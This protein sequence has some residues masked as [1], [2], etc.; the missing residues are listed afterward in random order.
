[1]LKLITG[2]DTGGAE[3]MLYKTVTHLDKDKYKPIV[4]SLLPEGRISGMLREQNSEVHSLGMRNKF[5]NPAVLFRLVAL[6]RREK[7]EILHS[8]MFHADLLGRIAGKLAGVPV[9]IS[10]I[11]N[12]NIGGKWRERML[13]VSDFMVDRVT[14]VCRAA[15]MKQVAAGTTRANKLH[16]IYN[17]IELGKYPP[18][19]DAQ[20]AEVRREWNIPDDCRVLMNVGRL[21]RQK[22]QAGL[23]NSFASLLGEEP[24]CRLVIVGDG[25]LRGALEEQAGRLGIA[26]RVIFTGICKDIPRML[27]AA[28]IFVLSSLWEGFPNVVI[29][30]M[31][32]RKPVVATNAGGTPEVIED[33]RSGLLVEPGNAAALTA[34][35]TRLLR[36][37][38][39]QLQAMGEYGRSVVERDFTI[40]RTIDQTE[41]M[42]EGLMREKGVPV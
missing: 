36:L 21:E 31:A 16:V 23:L 35:L 38:R 13:G 34:A 18:G 11:R 42:Y 12:E 37:P 5:P 27:Q 25:S 8:Y 29:E 41:R 6:L 20:R 17:G 19:T 30:A 1:M 26:D 24:D 39:Q 32:A 9:V 3:M 40:E 10:S 22:D 33:G 4:V 7:P 28:D 2:L 14:A 15:G